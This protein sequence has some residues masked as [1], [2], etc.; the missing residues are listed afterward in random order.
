MEENKRKENEKDNKISKRTRGFSVFVGN[1][2]FIL[3]RVGVWRLFSLTMPSF[4]LAQELIA[5]RKVL[6]KKNSFFKRKKERKKD[7]EN[8]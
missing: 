5:G 4:L 7:K 3:N 6:I 8:I 2:E 1:V